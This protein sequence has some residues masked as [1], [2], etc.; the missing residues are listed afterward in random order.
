MKKICPRWELNLGPFAYKA[1]SLNVALLVEIFIE[2]INVDRVFPKCAIKIICTVYHVLDV[3]KCFV[4]YY[5]LLILYS[6][7]TS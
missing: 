3:V 4:V 5:I 2:H 6:Q 7:Q 1:K